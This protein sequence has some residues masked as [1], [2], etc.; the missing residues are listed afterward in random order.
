VAGNPPT[1]IKVKQLQLLWDVCTRWDSVYHMISRLHAM[2]PVSYK[3][4]LYYVTS[5]LITPISKQALDDFLALPNHRDL[6]A[7]RLTPMEWQVLQDFEMILQVHFF[8]SWLTI[9]K[10][11]LIMKT[12]TISSTT[13]DVRRKDTNFIRSHSCL[14][15][16]HNRLGETGQ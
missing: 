1:T 13:N 15:I 16:I 12:G 5:W 7:Y 14:W 4:T 6:V 10:I 3:L 8:W 11:V 2:R 9:C